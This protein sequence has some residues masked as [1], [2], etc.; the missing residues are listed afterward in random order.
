MTEPTTPLPSD[1]IG[2]LS[3][4]DPFAS[5]ADRFTSGVQGAVAKELEDSA[6]VDLSG[7]TLGNLLIS[8]KLGAGGMGEVWLAHHEDLDLQVAVKVLGPE[9]SADPR[10]VGRFVTEA[11]AVARLDHP[12]IVRVLDAGK[13]EHLGGYLRVLVMEFVAGSDAHDL[14]R[15]QGGGG[16]DPRLAAEIALC[17][18]KALRY[19]HAKGVTHRDIK[20]AN[21]LVTKQNGGG[22]RVVAKV[23]DFGLAKLRGGREEPASPALTMAGTVI[24]TPQYMAPEQA[25]GKLVDGRSDV[26]SLGITLYEL[27]SGRLPFD[28]GTAYSIIKG[29]VEEPLEF[30]TA[31]FASVPSQFKELIGGMCQKSADDRWPLAQVIEKLEEYLGIS[32][33]S[34]VTPISNTSSKPRHNIVTPANRY[35]GRE[36]EFGEVAKLFDEGV[37]L[38]TLLG[39][40]GVGKT[41]FSQEFGLRVAGGSMSSSTNAPSSTR[42]K[43]D[44]DTNPPSIHF[45]DLTEARS[46]EGICHGVAQGVGVPLT[47]AD[48]IGQIHAALKLRGAMLVILDNFEQVT[49]F[50]DE[51]IGLWLQGTPNV[52]FLASSREPLHVQGERGYRLEPLDEAT[53]G[54]ELFVSRA[55][56]V[57]SSFA[58]DEAALAA[59]RQ[60]VQTLDGIPLAIELAAARTSAL[61][62]QK[63]LQMLPKRFDLLTS[64][65]RDASARQMTLRGAIDW[66]WNLLK[67]WE[68]AALAQCSVFQGGFLLDAALEVIDV[69]SI[70]DAPFVLDIIEA[71]V[72]KSLLRTSPALGLPGE[73]RYR[74]YESIREFAIWKMGE[75][76]SLMSS[77]VP[78]GEDRDGDVSVPDLR[79]RHAE[80]YV[81]YGEEWAARAEGP[82]AMEA[83]DRLQADCEN[84]L[85]VQDAFTNTDPDLAA[86]AL[87]AATEVIEARGP[88]TERVARLE[89]AVGSISRSTTSVSASQDIGPSTPTLINLHIALILAHGDCG[90]TAGAEAS[91][92]KAIELARAY[93]ESHS[94]PKADRLLAMALR[95]GADRINRS[96]KGAEARTALDEAQSLAES[97]GD[98]LLV[99]SISR[100]RALSHINQGDFAGAMACLDQAEVAHRGLGY[101]MGVAAYTGNRGMVYT[102]LGEHDKAL[103]CYE[104][105]IAIFRRLGQRD[106]MAGFIGNCGVVHFVRGDF[107]LAL[108]A[109]SEAEAIHREYGNRFSFAIWVGNRGGVHSLLGEYDEALRCH[110]EAEDVHRE[111]GEKRPL[112][113]WLSSRAVVRLRQHLASSNGKKEFLVEALTAAS[114]SKSLYEEVG[115]QNVHFYFF[116]LA[117]LSRVY[118]EL[119]LLPQSSECD[120]QSHNHRELSIATAQHARQLAEELTSSGAINLEREGKG[121]EVRVAFELLAPIPVG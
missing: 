114:E 110:F 11:R 54:V 46:V 117:T 36:R 10:F 33:P 47:T 14:V 112:A 74:M 97:I 21:I 13:R 121:S 43:V 30:P 88:F 69:E 64:R 7:L 75:M 31:A 102:A 76:G 100:Y 2:F 119:S 103:A 26:Y 35:I 94:G 32:S 65:R 39:P 115:A 96:G 67:P 60:I 24:G 34:V 53:A 4:V 57:K 98:R 1:G 63:I 37:R 52:Q 105:A 6:P 16:L 8:R 92:V 111:L 79:R 44:G 109:Y 89:L 5:L 84:L 25:L 62:P 68:Q 3:G 81:S 93:R 48:A 77:A 78:G 85:A 41:R 108:R 95:I 45:C 80:Y 73:L 120:E 106:M 86:R 118:W 70:P 82:M 107:Q 99:A 71:L 83:L 50:A 12:N 38:V 20:P 28:G 113:Y 56:D 19:A 15:E 58:P 27:L 104:E 90:T 18:A 91:T 51:T 66:S 61:T 29:H 55:K 23:L 59:I 17:V 87:L 9:L 116:T 40:G 49:E 22:G 72:D 42:S 101:Q